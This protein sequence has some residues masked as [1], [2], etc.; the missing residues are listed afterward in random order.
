M[1][2]GRKI[3]HTFMSAFYITFTYLYTQNVTVLNTE[4]T[5][6]MLQSQSTGIKRVQ[7]LNKRNTF[8][9]A[10][11]S[12]HPFPCDVMASALV[13][14]TERRVSARTRNQPRRME[15]HKRHIHACLPFRLQ[16]QL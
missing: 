9:G 12:G 10:R 6:K 14:R 5:V 13:K 15:V 8:I 1:N 11:H 16:R 2:V 7:I 4:N 3:Q